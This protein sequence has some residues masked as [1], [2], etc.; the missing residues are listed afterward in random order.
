M[1]IERVRAV[2]DDVVA[3][4][5]RLLPQLSNDAREPTVPAL[6]AV[7]AAPGTALLVARVDGVVVGSVTVVV[8]A[9]P[10]GAHAWLEDVVVDRAARGAGVGEA[11]VRAAL[12]EAEALGARTVDLTSS[13]P[14]QAAIRLYERVGF[15]RRDTSVFRHTTA[16]ERASP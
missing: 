5:S 7:V 15:R 3:S 6:R 4:L 16:G 10:S 13:P 8:Y 2:D 12:A 1:V 9:I 11:L 14:R